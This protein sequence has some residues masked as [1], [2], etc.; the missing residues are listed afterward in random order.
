MTRVSIGPPV[1]LGVAVAFLAVLSTSGCGPGGS[2]TSGPEV[3][4]DGRPV[5]YYANGQR[6]QAGRIEGGRETGPWTQWYSTGQRKAEGS[7]VSGERDGAWTY[8]HENGQ[9]AKQGTYLQGQEDGRWVVWYDSGQRAA[10]GDY[11]E[12]ER[13]GVWTYWDEDGKS[14]LQLHTDGVSKA[15][16]DLVRALGS[17]NEVTRTAAVEELQKQGVQALPALALALKQPSTQAKIAACQLVGQLEAEARAAAPL[18]AGLLSDTNE[19]VRR[20]AREALGRGDSLALDAVL[21]ALAHPDILTQYEALETLGQFTHL[22]ELAAPPADRLLAHPDSEMVRRA[23]EV[24]AKL[25]PT[26]LPLLIAASK[27]DRPM[28]RGWAYRGLAR[29]TSEYEEARTLLIAALAEPD[30]FVQPQ[31]IAALAESDPRMIDLLLDRLTHAPSNERQLASRSLG[32][33]GTPAIARLVSLLSDSRAENRYWAAI[34]LG[35]MG[36]V[37]KPAIT[38]LQRATEDSDPTVRNYAATALRKIRG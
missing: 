12:G 21:T 37:A 10:E 1:R 20:A 31:L 16:M 15:S 34:S 2:A 6:Q 7:F 23:A 33:I 25:A 28:T 38:A 14:R 36:S 19:D 29:L 8:W 13:H 18:M 35:E 4:P 9:V 24:L 30:E 3:A 5:V 11:L 26:G 32:R 17:V 27:S 22:P